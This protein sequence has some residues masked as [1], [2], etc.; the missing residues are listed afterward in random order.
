MQYLFYQPADLVDR[1]CHAANRPDR[2]VTFLVGSPISAPDH[3]GGHGV[4]GVGAM[5]DLIRDEFQGSNAEAE[6]NQSLLD[7][8]NQYQTA[9]EFL[10]AKRG[11]DAVNGIVR[12]SVW[13]ALNARNWPSFLPDT[14]PDEADS[15]TCSALERECDA[16]ILPAAADSLAE[17]LV[18]CSDTFGDAI[19]TTNF[20]PLIEVGVC[21]YGGQYYRTVLHGDGRLGQT[22]ADGTHIVH[23]H[24]YWCD[25][26]TLHTPSQLLQPRPRLA[27]SLAYIVR[28]STLA[29][30]G[31]GGW[32][33]VVTQAL[34]DL[35][36]DSSSNPEILWAFHTKDE[37]TVAQTHDRLLPILAPGIGRG[38]VSLFRGVEC[39][40]L[41]SELLNQLK[42]H[43][44]AAVP[45]GHGQQITA[46]VQEERGR[47]TRPSQVRIAIDFPM[48]Q[49]VSSDSDRPL[50]VDCWVGRSQ[51]LQFLDTTTTPV[52]VITGL[53]G[54]GKSALAGR[55]VQLRAM[56]T[57]SRYEF[58]DWRDCRE[59]SDRLGTQILRLVERLSEGAVDPSRVEGTNMRAVVGLLFQVLRDRRAL[60]VFDNIDQYIDLE[61]FEPTKGLDIFVGEAQ[62]RSH[63]SLFLFTCRPD[64]AVDESRALRI[65]LDGL[66]V[67]E[68]EQLVGARGVPRRDVEL[69]RNLHEVT[70]GHP[71]WVNLIVMQALRHADGLRGALEMTIR[72]GGTLPDTTRTIWGI[73]NT[74]QRN[75]LRTM[76]ELDRP[77]PET[78][79]LEFLPGLN[80]N[81]V[82][83]ALRALRSFHLIEVWTQAEGEPHLGLHPLIREF[84]RTSFPQR[85]R[86]KYV[87]AILGYLER[88]VGR[89]R[90][91]LEK[92]PGYQVLEHWTRKADLQITIGRLEAATATI[93]E[94]GDPLVNR[95]YAEEL[96]RLALRLMNAVNWGEACSSYKDFDAVFSRCLKAMVELGHEAVDTQ[97]VRYELAIPGKSAQFILL[98]DLRC[99]AEW[100]SGQYAAAVR[101]G[102]M[103]ATLK[104]ETAVDTVFSTHHNLALAKRE[105]GHVREALDSFLGGEALDIVVAAGHRLEDRG[106][107]FYGNIGR[108]LHLLER[109]DEALVCYVKSAQLL[110]GRRDHEDRLNKGYARCWTAELLVQQGEVTL[111]AI[112][113]RAAVCV[114]RECSPPRAAEAEKR[115][116]ALVAEH[117]ELQVYAEEVD[118]RVE[119]AFGEWLARQ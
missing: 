114:W 34:M 29:V 61:T 100:Y 111:A 36:D 33:D 19:L 116:M 119:G 93:E 40:Y 6:L 78:R 65:T 117:G 27:A 67:E 25:S 45:S 14:T 50:L 37:E 80:A 89:F 98:C 22:V 3:V 115:L 30:I 58:W 88:M 105:A 74:H 68:T 76:A 85:E 8:D 62:A 7:S 109:Y 104:K 72:G 2:T 99:Y 23:L 20:D 64:V 43:Y 83:R 106:A 21:K 96:V 54:Q 82:G 28:K 103:G 32:D 44:P 24:G 59:E 16:W 102:E 70:G 41:F 42:P 57:N 26:D 9:F 11:Q 90:G 60:L 5:V 48:P 35:L 97:L 1:L 63:R 113:Y 95:G 12:A 108:C 75:V 49:L 73:L 52:A 15:V 66:T 112:A 53:G 91:V 39:Q 71:L 86:Q 79:L 81:R 92:E 118:W 18:T 31:Y 101:W 46:R 77:E 55:F 94:V 87:G 84:V 13:R 38:R 47:G 10:H 69:V 4:P 110:E 17:L 51:E 56:T 107:H